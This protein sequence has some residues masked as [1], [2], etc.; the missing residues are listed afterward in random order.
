MFCTKTSSVLKVRSLSLM[1]DIDL[2]FPCMSILND[3]TS[4]IPTICGNIT[5]TIQCLA[6]DP[7]DSGFRTQAW[8]YY[9]GSRTENASI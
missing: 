9:K 8:L 5:W 7:V 3:A 4:Q 6:F 1:G 2:E